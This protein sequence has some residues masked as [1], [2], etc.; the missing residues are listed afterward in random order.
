MHSDA[1]STSVSSE[2]ASRSHGF[3]VFRFSS[4]S[5]G[6][7][8]AQIAC[9]PVDAGC[10]V[11]E[12]TTCCGGDARL[13]AHVCALSSLSPSIAASAGFGA[14]YGT[15][16]A[17]VGIAS[18]GVMRP[19]LVM[20]SIVPVVM[21]G[22]LGIYGLI[23][24]VIIGTNSESPRLAHSRPSSPAL[25]PRPRRSCSSLSFGRERG[26]RICGA[27]LSAYLSSGSLRVSTL[28]AAGLSVRLA[29]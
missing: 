11:G 21:A 25:G 1:L 2:W 10:D 13:L 14:A 9:D 6:R 7:G 4:A 5:H 12:T 27:L 22:V 18:M 3:A 29:L 8:R 26:R 28:P 24:A 20:K 19:E 23:V 16:K 15:A 17:G